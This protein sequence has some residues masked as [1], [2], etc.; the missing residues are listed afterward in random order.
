MLAVVHFVNGTTKKYRHG[1]A[2]N[3]QS[4]HFMVSK[5]N[6]KRRKLEDLKVS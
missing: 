5:W 4:P 2:A 6:S 3:L 1:E